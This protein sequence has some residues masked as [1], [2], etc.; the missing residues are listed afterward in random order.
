MALNANPQDGIDAHNRARDLYK[1]T[2]HPLLAAEERRPGIWVM[3]AQFNDEYG[4]IEFKGDHYTARARWK[5]T[6]DV[7]QLG[8]F[9]RLKP[10]A[11]AVHAWWSRMHTPG[12]P[13]SSNLWAGPPSWRPET[14]K[15]PLTSRSQ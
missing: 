12:Q 8:T 7:V 5:Q 9:P 10:A 4:V 1:P 14:Q 6:G 15:S 13:A 2:W 3:V 11:E